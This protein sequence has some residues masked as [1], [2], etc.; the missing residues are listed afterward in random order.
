MLQG[1]LVVCGQCIGFCAEDE[2]DF[3]CVVERSAPQCASVTP[4]R[5]ETSLKDIEKSI[6][7][8]A[9]SKELRTLLS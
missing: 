9:K 1:K 5:G 8:R 4:S 3:G 2:K 7:S 6:E